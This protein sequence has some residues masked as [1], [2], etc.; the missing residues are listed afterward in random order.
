ML[1]GDSFWSAFL[2]GGDTFVGYLESVRSRY[3]PDVP[4]SALLRTPDLAAA[5][6]VIREAV[7]EDR[8]AGRIPAFGTMEGFG[9][10]A[11]AWFDND[12]PPKWMQY[13]HDGEGSVRAAEPPY[14]VERSVFQV[15]EPELDYE[16][17][18]GSPNQAFRVHLRIPYSLEGLAEK[19]PF[20]H[21]LPT[22]VLHEISDFGAGERSRREHGNGSF[23]VVKAIQRS[24]ADLESGRLTWKVTI[25]A[26]GFE[27]VVHE[28]ALSAPVEITSADIDDVTS[29]PST[30][31]GD[32]LDE[33]R[34]VAAAATAA[35]SRALSAC[36]GT[37]DA[38]SVAVSSRAA[39]SG[40]LDAWPAPT[41][42]SA[43][44]GEL[45]ALLARARQAA[46]Q[47]AAA[48]QAL[49]PLRGEAG[50]LRD[51]LCA[52]APPGAGALA[53]AS[54]LSGLQSAAAARFAEAERALAELRGIAAQI[55]AMATPPAGTPDSWL[56][57]V[58]AALDELEHRLREAGA[59]ADRAAGE[60]EQ[61][62]VLDARGSDLLQRILA[63]LEIAGGGTFAAVTREVD[64]LFG[65]IRSA[66][67]AAAGC[68][69]AAARAATDAERA[70]LG[71]LRA[72]AE[73]L[74]AREGVAAPS[75]GA[76]AA[77]AEVAS[78][79]A[80]LEAGVAAGEL[81]RDSIQERAAQ[82]RSCSE[83]PPAGRE[84]GGAGG[85]PP[86]SGDSPP[87]TDRDPSLERTEPSGGGSPGWTID[88]G[89]RTTGS[90]TQ[91]PPRAAPTPPAPEP[92]PSDPSAEL[93]GAAEAAFA[94][95]DL[96]S[97]LSLAQQL[98]AVA[99]DHPWLA[100][101]LGTLS[102][103]AAQQRTTANHLQIAQTLFSSGRLDRARSALT[104]AARHAPGCMSGPIAG[105]VGEVNSA[106]AERREANRQA[107]SQG[108]GSLLGA[109]GQVASAIAANGGNSGI[110]PPAAAAP[111]GHAHGHDG[112][113]LSGAGGAA[114]PTCALMDINA[115]PAGWAQQ[116]ERDPTV[117]WYIQTK[118][119][120][121]TTFYSIAPARPEELQRMGQVAGTQYSGPYASA[122]AAYQAA[123]ARCPNVVQPSR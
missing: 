79:L 50:A 108:L 5:V 66:V 106:A 18:E 24:R 32:L 100:A 122:S 27:P 118:T 10:R 84:D 53:E 67:D 120:S 2:A 1:S 11:E 80:D 63:S 23:E 43:T 6:A 37:L 95:C 30:D 69:P 47:G 94:R 48:V 13:D 49:G 9:G 91:P 15:G 64:E 123:R 96:V 26:Y 87:A 115:Y 57:S 17:I 109:I 98:A 36:H 81:F 28:L 3:Y 77:A 72:R 14:A 39:I 116:F 25:Q 29:Q 55:A 88:E 20:L 102:N 51:A 101:N 19:L 92:P 54:R 78:L 121:A 31:V 34:A 99:P 45:E 22:L 46:A 12:L 110:L 105:L 71:I 93:I 52:S 73:E 61:L 58:V 33:L 70:E 35:S 68:D 97:A 103:L 41:A 111:S 75:A 86:S 60:R 38:V 62:S 56:G 65:R 74:R 8:R 114:T 104:D 16:P 90:T 21:P 85:W 83:R 112:R 44:S 113:D 7:A 76:E 40:R 59:L 117:R 107:L 119:L 42:S 4:L 89:V 82:S